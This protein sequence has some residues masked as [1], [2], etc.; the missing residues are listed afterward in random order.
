VKTCTNY[1]SRPP[2]PVRFA[3]IHPCVKAHA[4]SD[5]LRCPRG[6]QINGG[7]IVCLQA[8]EAAIAERKAAA[9]AGSDSGSGLPEGLKLEPETALLQPGKEGG[10]MK[11]IQEDGTGMVYTWDADK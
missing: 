8:Y 2:W 1:N 5:H 11:V 3:C 4:A 6:P 9:A 7:V 10:D